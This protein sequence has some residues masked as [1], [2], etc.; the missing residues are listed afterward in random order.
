[1]ASNSPAEAAMLA[2]GPIQPSRTW[3]SEATWKTFENGTFHGV[4]RGV[5]IQKSD[6]DLERYK[7]II[8]ISQPDLVI[9]TGTRRGGSALWFADQ[10]LKVI[11]IDLVNDPGPSHP[12]IWYLGGHSSV[13]LPRSTM[14][15]IAET[16]SDK[17]V[18]VSLD[19]DHHAGHVLAE[20]A[21]W[22]SFV[23]PGCYLVVE[24]A[25]FDMWKPERARVGGARIP[26]LGGPLQAI[27]AAATERV[28]DGFWRD[29][30]VE[31][32]TSISHSP[33]GWWRREE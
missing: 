14:E 22:R 17:R 27:N 2:E 26:E 7:E 33:C 11:T 6:D 20:V 12:S 29:K 16:C 25:C 9:E 28:L 1:M 5:E 24:D 18:M 23:T 21:L 13:D 30:A 4:V 15:T 32:M 3:D 10:G 31:T 8:E 19:S